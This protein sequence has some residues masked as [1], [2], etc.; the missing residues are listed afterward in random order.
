MRFLLP[1]HSGVQL[2]LK[3]ERERDN[4]L[5]WRKGRGSILSHFEVQSELTASKR[6]E[7]QKNVLKI[8]I[9]TQYLFLATMTLITSPL[10]ISTPL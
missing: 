7:S 6:R 4:L 10:A 8:D 5:K 1:L 3:R 9:C 2:E